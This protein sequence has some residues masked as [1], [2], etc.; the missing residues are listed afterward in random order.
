MAHPHKDQHSALPR[1]E[2]LSPAATWLTL[3]D[4]MLGAMS[5][6]HKDKGHVIP[7]L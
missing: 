2:I 5:Q 4:T 1:K 6:S 3:G 7:L